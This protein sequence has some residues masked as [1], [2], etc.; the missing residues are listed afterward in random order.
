[1]LFLVEFI[2]GMLQIEC[3]GI[4]EHSEKIVKANRLDHSKSGDIDHS[5]FMN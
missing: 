2:V 5:L 1:M 4:V 3:S